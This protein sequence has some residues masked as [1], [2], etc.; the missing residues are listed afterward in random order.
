[1]LT[2]LLS[3]AYAHSLRVHLAVPVSWPQIL[4]ALHPSEVVLPPSPEETFVEL[5]KTQ[6]SQGHH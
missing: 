2:L 4:S 1:M 3:P 5:R 6:D